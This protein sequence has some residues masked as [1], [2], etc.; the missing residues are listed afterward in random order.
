MEVFLSC[1]YC[2]ANLVPNRIGTI[3]IIAVQLIVVFRMVMQV[4]GISTVISVLLMWLIM[5]IISPCIDVG[6]PCFA[7]DPCEVDIVGDPRLMADFVYVGADKFD[8]LEDPLAHWQFDETSGTTAYDTT[9]TYNGTLQGV[10][11]WIP[12]WLSIFRWVYR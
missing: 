7:G 11:C 10:P 6:D 9:G 2:R 1:L 3:Y 8:R 12:R 5:S 4:Q